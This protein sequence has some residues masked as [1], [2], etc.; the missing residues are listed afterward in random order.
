MNNPHTHT[1][2]PK[3]KNCERKEESEKRQLK[4]INRVIIII[5]KFSW[6]GKKGVVFPPPKVRSKI[7]FLIF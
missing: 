3:K 5:K 1:T 6:N 2:Q 4:S 7:F